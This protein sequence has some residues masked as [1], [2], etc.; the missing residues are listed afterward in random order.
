MNYEIYTY[1]TGDF[2]LYVLNGVA[3][4]FGNG[5]FVFVLKTAALLG[6]I[7]VVVRGAFHIGRVDVS[8]ILGMMLV[9]TALILPKV[10][11]IINDRVQP[12]N[13]AVVQHVPLGI[14]VTASL[15]STFG[16]WLT[17]AFETVFSLPDQVQ[18]T[19][20]GLLF[21]NSLIQSATQFEVVTP[22]VS[23]NFAEF[24]QSC[25]YYDLLLGKYSWDDLVFSDDLMTFLKQNTAVA[26]SFTYR[27]TS[28]IPTT[29]WC[30]PGINN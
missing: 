28:N 13:N 4:I 29:L 12:V 6:L 8:W 20:N 27:D 5:D 17:R 19:T 1:G 10:T 30:R 21:S 25:V 26:R 15:F 14:G 3:A 23:A 2:L 9:Y 16:D 11:V 24:W 7:S 22:R 18:Y